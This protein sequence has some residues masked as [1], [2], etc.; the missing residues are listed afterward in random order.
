MPGVDRD[1]PAFARLT[2]P[3]RDG[4]GVNGSYYYPTIGCP[5][6][7]PRACEGS[8]HIV[9]HGRITARIRVRVKPGV[10][11]VFQVR[12]REAACPDATAKD[13]LHTRDSLGRV[14]RIVLTLARS[15]YCEPSRQ[16]IPTGWITASS[17]KLVGQA[18]L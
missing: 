7:M 17:A 16:T 4:G 8:L 13:I 5:Q 10:H 1:G 6:D 18:R 14:R 15:G 3:F 12:A 2:P 11:N 9:R